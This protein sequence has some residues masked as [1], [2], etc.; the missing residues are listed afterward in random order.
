M[1]QE[2]G[3]FDA[4]PS[5]LTTFLQTL[6]SQKIV[7]LYKYQ[8]TCQAVFR[9]LP[10]V[11]RQYVLRL[12]Y[13]D[14]PIPQSM[15]STDRIATKLIHFHLDHLANMITVGLSSPKELRSY[16]QCVFE[17]IKTIHWVGLLDDLAMRRG[18]CLRRCDWLMDRPCTCWE[19]SG[20]DGNS[21][22][23]ADS[24][25]GQ[26]WVRISCSCFES[27]GS[28]G[29]WVEAWLGGGGIW[30]GEAVRVLCG[31]RQVGRAGFQTTSP[32]SAQS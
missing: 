22:D 4:E 1:V 17:W 12:L 13:V 11:A 31:W 16:L 7:G 26:Q 25:G 24:W 20:G 19:A 8:W 21:A 30:C 29:H 9:S 3:M 28:T 14:Q 6:P 18:N 15:I 5:N 27:Q 23:L 10:T 32:I 2:I